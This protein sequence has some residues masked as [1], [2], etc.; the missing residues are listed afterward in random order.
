MSRESYAA[1]IVR[2]RRYLDGLDEN[3]AKSKAMQRQVAVLTAL[4]VRAQE[5]V[6][7]RDSLR[8][9]MQT[10][11]RELQEVLRTGRTATAYLRAA[12][13]AHVPRDSPE[14]HKLGIKLGGRPRGRKKAP[15]SRK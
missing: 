13:R 6:R 1:T 11:T 9:S 2:W 3:L 14:L 7:E 5:L 12:V 4:Y 10:T 15:A 8:A